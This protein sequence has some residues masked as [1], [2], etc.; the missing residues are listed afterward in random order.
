MPQAPDLAG[1]LPALDAVHNLG[2]L[3]SISADLVAYLQGTSTGDVLFSP[4]FAPASESLYASVASLAPGRSSFLGAEAMSQ[5][6]LVTAMSREMALVGVGNPRAAAMAAAEAEA[7]TDRLYYG[8]QQVVVGRAL[9]AT[10]REQR[11][12]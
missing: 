12:F 5:L 10:S 11:G 8:N 4:D 1:S 3:E 9:S 6:S 7:E 2:L